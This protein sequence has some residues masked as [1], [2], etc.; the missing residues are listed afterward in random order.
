M[1]SGGGLTLMMIE[2]KIP[3]PPLGMFMNMEKRK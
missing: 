1:E 3:I 2:P